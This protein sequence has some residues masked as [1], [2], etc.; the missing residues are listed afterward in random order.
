M[1]EGWRYLAFGIE[2][3]P[4]SWEDLRERARRG[5]LGADNQVRQGEQ[6]PWLP[7]GNVPGLLAASDDAPPRD[8][9]SWYCEVLGAELG[10]MSWEDLCLLARRGNLNADNRVRRGGNADWIRA[11]SVAGLI[12]AS[13]QTSDDAD[14]ELADAQPLA[15]PASLDV[16]FEIDAPKPEAKRTGH[17]EY[18]DGDIDS[19]ALEAPSPALSSSLPPPRIPH[20]AATSGAP[21]PAVSALRSKHPTPPNRP[22]ARLAPSNSPRASISLQLPPRLIGAVAATVVL[23]ALSWGGYLAYQR[24]GTQGP[25]YR[26]VAS[27]YQQVYEELKQFR[28]DPRSRSPM[29]LKFQFSRRVAALRDQMQDAQPDSPEARLGQA[30]SQLSEMLN[31]FS[32]QPGSPEESKFAESEQQFLTLIDR[33]KSELIP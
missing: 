25:D 11:A 24:L 21:P 4:M 30:G 28:Q 26:Q 16:D 8:D 22:Q 3:G 18:A 10:P 27:S 2:L 29:G 12:A 1:S 9:D 13:D 15:P 20:E 31:S 17:V 14:F 7:A 23:A 33:V 19:P 6:G 5:D 32:A